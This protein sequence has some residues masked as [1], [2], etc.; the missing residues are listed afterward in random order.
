MQYDAVILEI[1]RGQTPTQ[2][3]RGHD[4]ADFVGLK[5]GPIPAVNLRPQALPYY[6]GY[7]VYLIKKNSLKILQEIEIIAPGVTSR[8]LCISDRRKK[9]LCLVDAS[10]IRE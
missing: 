5:N 8:T 3:L 9:A 2:L 4:Y 7:K 6:L 10:H 1:L